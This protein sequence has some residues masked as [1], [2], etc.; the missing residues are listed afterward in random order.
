[1][2]N[3]QDCLGNWRC[4]IAWW[5]ASPEGPG[6][7]K[8]LQSEPEVANSKNDH[9]AIFMTKAMPDPPLGPYVSIG[10]LNL[11]PIFLEEMALAWVEFQCNYTSLCTKNCIAPGNSFPKYTGL[12]NTGNKL[13]DIRLLQLDPGWQSQSDQAH[14][15][16]Y[17][18]FASQ[19]DSRRDPLGIPTRVVVIK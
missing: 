12:K 1:M 2:L 18:W 15:Y 4:L 10:S 3:M 11:E 14:S 7:V 16:L 9:Y 6:H 8:L 13:P 19:W 17:P 5:S